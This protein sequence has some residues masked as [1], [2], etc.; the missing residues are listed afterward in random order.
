MRYFV[1]THDEGRTAPVAIDIHG[2]ACIHYTFTVN[3]KI[4]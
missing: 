4:W 1:S 3:L 2:H